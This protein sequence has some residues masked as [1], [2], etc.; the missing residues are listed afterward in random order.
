MRVVLAGLVLANLALFAWWQG[1]FDPAPAVGLAEL[2]PERVRIA[3]IERLGEPGASRIPAL[4]GESTPPAQPLA[5]EPAQAG[6]VPPQVVAERSPEPVCRAF[7]FAGEAAARALAN[8]LRQTGAQV[9]TQ[10]PAAPT[11]YLV[12]LPPA[13]SLAEAQQRVAA[14][15]R[16]GVDDVFLMPEGALRLGISLGLFTREAGAREV[17]AR[18]LALGYDA[19]IAPRPQGAGSWRLLARWPGAAEADRGLAAVGEADADVQDCSRN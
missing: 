9:E 14:L 16:A 6:G 11:S 18:L 4:S 7:S 8:A 10:P 19:R 17:A 1:V 5:A 12:Y 3:S 13:D 15:R 2:A